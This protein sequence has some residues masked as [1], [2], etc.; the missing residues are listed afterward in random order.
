MFDLFKLHNPELDLSNKSWVCF[1]GKNL[2]KIL[3]YKV[4][5]ITYK[6]A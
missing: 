6:I 4:R 2:H 3:P 1:K 5:I